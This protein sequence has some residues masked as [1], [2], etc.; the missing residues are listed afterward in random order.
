LSAAAL[1]FQG[2]GNRCD[3]AEDFTHWRLEI[4]GKKTSYAF[5][6]ELARAAD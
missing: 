1:I 6:G 2:R 3:N 5:F 4:S